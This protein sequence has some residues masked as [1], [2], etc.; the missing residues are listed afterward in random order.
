VGVVTLHASS[1][2]PLVQS[3]ALE[4]GRIEA[5]NDRGD[6][7]AAVL[8]VTVPIDL[9]ATEQRLIEGAIP[10]TYGEL[11]LADI[12]ALTLVVG[13][14]PLTIA[15]G[16]SAVIELR[17]PDGGVYLPFGGSIAMDVDVD[18]APVLA[19]LIDA[20]L[21]PPLGD[22]TTDDAD[23]VAALVEALGASGVIACSAL[24]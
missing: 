23:I 21:F 6:A 18:F 22:T 9:L 10:A 7:L 19:S 8:P 4:V 12:G 13:G 16:G 11:D 1:L 5:H 15:L 24:P 14:F 20:G 17:C 2:G 3:A